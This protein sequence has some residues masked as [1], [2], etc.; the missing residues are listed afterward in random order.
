MVQQFLFWEY[1][2]KKWKHLKIYLHPHIQS[3]IISN[4]QDM[5]ATHVSIDGWMRKE[6]GV[7]PYFPGGWVVKN[8]PISPGYRRDAGLRSLGQGDPLEQEMATHCSVLAW[9]TPWT[10]EPGGYSP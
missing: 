5:K 3:S 9:E 2:Q 4:S 6:N 8:S 10:V 7:H 1:I